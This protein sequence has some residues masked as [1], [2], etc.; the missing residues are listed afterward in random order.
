[1][2]VFLSNKV[3]SEQ[4]IVGGHHFASKFFLL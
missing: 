4:E 2:T 1:M 3:T